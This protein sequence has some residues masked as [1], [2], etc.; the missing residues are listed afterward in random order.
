[1]VCVCR[2]CGAETGDHRAGGLGV[3]LRVF[4]PRALTRS[5]RL[6]ILRRAIT[7]QPR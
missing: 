6:S 2:R 4:H 1:M 3:A 7:L 5:K